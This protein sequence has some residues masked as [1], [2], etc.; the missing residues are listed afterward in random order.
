MSPDSMSPS[1]SKSKMA[2]ST[3]LKVDGE[4]GA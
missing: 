3:F 1:L 4:P 2:F